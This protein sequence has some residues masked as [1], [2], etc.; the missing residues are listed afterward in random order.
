MDFSVLNIRACLLQTLRFP[1][2]KH[3]LHLQTKFIASK[4]IKLL[5]ALQA[6]LSGIMFMKCIHLRNLLLKNEDGARG[7]VR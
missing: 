5:A 6:R 2:T 1:Y 7:V 3:M 4:F